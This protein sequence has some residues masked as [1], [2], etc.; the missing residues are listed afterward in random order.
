MENGEPFCILAAAVSRQSNQR[1]QNHWQRETTDQESG[2]Y[3]LANGSQHLT[4]KQ[5]I[6][7]SAVSPITNQARGPRC[8]EGDGGQARAL[9]VSHAALRDAIRGPRSEVL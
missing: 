9:G 4:A 7:G 1:R 8:D 3:R 2:Q 5:Y 6:L